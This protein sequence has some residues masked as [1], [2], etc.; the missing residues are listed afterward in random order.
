MWTD[1]A[2]TRALA[3]SGSLGSVTHLSSVSGSAWFSS[4][5]TYSQD[6]FDHATGKGSLV[7]Y[8]SQWADKYEEVL[9]SGEVASGLGPTRGNLC[10]PVVEMFKRVLE[11]FTG[12]A[13]LRLTNWLA[14]IEEA[15]LAPFVPNA[16]ATFGTARK[17]AGAAGV[18]LM[19][20]S[21]LPPAAWQKVGDT[22]MNTDLRMGGKNVSFLIPACYVAPGAST[23]ASG[24]LLHSPQPLTFGNGSLPLKLPEDPKISMS[25]AASSAAEGKYASKPLTMQEIEDA[26]SGLVPG[27]DPFGVFQKSV[28]QLNSLLETCL[29]AGLQNLA[30]PLE[31]TLNALYP[32]YRLI[33][34]GYTETTS[35]AFNVGKMQADCRAGRFDCA[36]KKLIIFS[37]A[38]PGGDSKDLR[39]LFSEPGVAPGEV[40]AYA[41]GDYPAP[42]PTIFREKWSE[43][44]KL[45]RPYVPASMNNGTSSRW[46][47]TTLHTVTNAWYNVHEGDAV[48]VALFQPRISVAT[49]QV[50]AVEVN[51]INPLERLQQS[52][53]AA[54]AAKAGNFFGFTNRSQAK[55]YGPPNVLQEKMLLPI[56]EAFVRGA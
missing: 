27:I 23:D 21:T 37:M 20:C 6:F 41:E 55:E 48:E 38:S 9:K 26:T 10:R 28:D 15:V 32:T 35:A 51:S 45:F 2:V 44:E 49:D 8:I 14:Y 18:T 5:F 52:I 47:N 13:N 22:T 46:L 29:P 30:V 43:V 24:W 12:N 50:P 11:S 19:Q 34:G 33:D 36:E 4:L 53:T 17:V 3:A 31:G 42:R 54:L 56:L 1:F 40:V 25:T 7:G 16:E 39:Q